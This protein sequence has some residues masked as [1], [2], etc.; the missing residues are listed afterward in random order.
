MSAPHHL[1]LLL[2]LALLVLPVPGAAQQSPDMPG[3]ELPDQVPSGAVLPRNL[4]DLGAMM[5]DRVGELVREEG[6][7][8]ADQGP[9]GTTLDLFTG[10]TDEDPNLTEIRRIARELETQQSVMVKLSDLQ[11]DLID[12]AAQDPSA[13]YRSRIPKEVCAV[14]ISPDVCENLTA[15]FR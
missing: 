15:S 3:M 7:A 13:A 9:E 4:N 5:A 8:E 11:S 2:A 10:G 14:A 1:P 12:F 6:I